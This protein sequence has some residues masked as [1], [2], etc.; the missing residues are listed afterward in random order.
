VQEQII[1][2]VMCW[3]VRSVHDQDRLLDLGVA[4]DL[5]TIAADMAW[6]L[7]PAEPAYGRKVTQ[8]LGLGR[9]A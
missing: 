9:P 6:L 2:N 5:I 7:D 4:P 8:R 1:P 3:S